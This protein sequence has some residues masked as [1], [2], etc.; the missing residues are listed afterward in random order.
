MFLR[1]WPRRRGSRSLGIAGAGIAGGTECRAEHQRQRERLTVADREAEER[2][3]AFQAAGR[4]PAVS[5]LVNA[6]SEA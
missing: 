3:L 4:P 5:H 1:S 2:A 6:L